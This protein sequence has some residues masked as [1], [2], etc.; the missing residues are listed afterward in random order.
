[1]ADVSV[2]W[3]LDNSAVKAL[4]TGK[5]GPV[6]ADL[7]RRCI[8]VET[9]AK[10]NLR[11]A[12]RIDTGRLLNSVT[13]EIRGTSAGPI[14]V[15]GSNLPY[16]RYVHDGTGIYGPTGRPIR[17]KSAR[18]LAWPVRGTTSARPS[19]RTGRIVTTR[20]Q[21]PTGMVFSMSSRGVPAVPFLRDALR[22][23][24]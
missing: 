2:T 13:H 22:E 10:R 17:P 4:L 14:G 11:A 16:A 24:A 18:V 15:V 23:A 7:T 9:A 5:N 21:R 8:R 1:M 20:S 6:V 3:R 12:G 19:A